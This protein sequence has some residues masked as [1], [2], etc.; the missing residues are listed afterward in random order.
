MAKIIIFGGFLGS[1]KTTVLKAFLQYLSDRPNGQKINAAVIENEI[2]EYS[3]DDN[4]IKQQGVKVKTLYSG[5]I[6]CTL[7]TS[8][9]DGISE[10]TEKYDPEYIIIETTGMAV[11]KKI[12][13]NLLQYLQKEVTICTIT[14]A[15]RWEKL[16]RSFAKEFIE[17]QLTDADFIWINK[18]DTVDRE[19]TEHIANEV[20]QFS[21]NAVIRAI[22]AKNGIN[23]ALFQQ[24]IQGE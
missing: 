8:L 20:K 1:G 3:V 14:D 21:N 12:R 13:E 2:G 24:L 17:S 10:I 19:K 15:A 16:T 4:V 5:C 7:Q 9:I 23:K 6:C 11:P 18:T 22:S